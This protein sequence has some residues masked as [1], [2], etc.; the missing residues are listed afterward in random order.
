MKEQKIRGRWVSYDKA[1]KKGI[2]NA[3]KDG[4]II[5]KTNRNFYFDLANCRFY[6]RE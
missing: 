3:S 1:R 6:E 5:I 4:A 2:M